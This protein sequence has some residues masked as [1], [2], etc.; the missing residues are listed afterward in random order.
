M[1]LAWIKVKGTAAVIERSVLPRTS[2]AV[3]LCRH[4]H[5]HDGSSRLPQRNGI[6]PELTVVDRI[7]GSAYNGPIAKLQRYRDD[8]ITDFGA[9]VL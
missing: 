7:F 5:E 4:G 1:R 8:S 2:T 6:R 9:I 3:P